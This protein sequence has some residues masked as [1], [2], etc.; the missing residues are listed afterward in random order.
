L[1]RSR[2]CDVDPRGN[3]IAGSSII[4]AAARSGPLGLV[5]HY[6]ALQELTVALTDLEFWYTGDEQTNQVRLSLV[7]HLPEALAPWRAYLMAEL[8]RYA[9]TNGE[10]KP[11]FLK[12][13]T[14]YA[15]ACIR[16]VRDREL[17]E[18]RGM[19]IN[20]AIPTEHRAAYLALGEYLY[21]VNDIGVV[22]LKAGVLARE[23][24]ARAAMAE[25]M[26]LYSME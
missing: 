24:A 14:T 26:D 21:Y 5:S 10:P 2:R 20:N 9:S 22:E 19:V 7:A 8:N 1:N 4:T 13:L 17:D 15:C 25:N 23:I 11:E 18:A 16:T 6:S 3:T 12:H